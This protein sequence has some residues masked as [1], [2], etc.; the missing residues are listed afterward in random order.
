MN[1][2]LLAVIGA[3]VLLATSV[4]PGLARISQPAAS[5]TAVRNASPPASPTDESK[6]PHYFGPYPNW[7]NSPLTMPD[8]TVVITGDGTGAAATATVGA[9]GAV[10]DVALTGG[11]HGYSN[12]KIDITGAGT[13]AAADATIV[14]KGAVVSVVVTAPGAGYTAPTVSFSGN[15][16][17]TASASGGVDVIAIGTQGA[18]Y[19]F[20]TV[21]F[22]LPDDPNGTQ[23]QGH[24]VCADPYPD[25]KL[26]V[27]TDVLAVTGVVV[28]DPGSGYASAPGVVVRDGT[29]FDPINHGTDPFTQATATATLTILAVTVDASGANYSSVPTVTISDP[30]GSGALATAALDNGVISAIALKKGGSGYITPGGIRKFVDT[31]P[32]LTEAGANNLGQ[33]IPVAQPDTST[34]ANADYYVIAVVQHREQMSSSL[35]TAGTLLREYVQLSTGVVPGKHVALNMDMPDGTST[36]VLMPDGSQAFGVDNPHYLGPTIVASKDRAVRIVFYNLLPTGA[37]GDLFLPTDTTIMGS[38]MTPSVTGA[39]G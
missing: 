18:G 27:Q 38:G 16:G 25:C 3:I 15:G 36:P 13:G 20:P 8:A 28:D 35:P 1:R 29:V 33:Y 14:K 22:D 39:P 9:N 19:K 26:T 34:F 23:A 7:A 12:V 6:V 30:T 5:G 21:D 4:T 2:K 11:G 37:D 17:A 31:L 24:A 32:G 10:T